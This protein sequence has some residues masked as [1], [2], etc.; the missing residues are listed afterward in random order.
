MDLLKILGWIAV[1]FCITAN[2][3]VVKKINAYLLWFVGTGILLVLA[4]L[5]HNWSQ[6]MLF[7]IYEVIN[8]WGFLSWRN[9]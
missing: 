1:V 2:I 3:L 9:V 6:C 4:V 7:G 8:F 5:D